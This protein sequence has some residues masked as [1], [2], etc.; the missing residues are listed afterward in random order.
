MVYNCDQRFEAYKFTFCSR[1]L[2]DNLLE[3]SC[4]SGLPYVLKLYVFYLHSSLFPTVVF[5][6]M[7]VGSVF[8]ISRSLLNFTSHYRLLILINWQHVLSDS[9][10]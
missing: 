3:K 8:I 9:Y 1:Y 5:E 4:S 10:I 6:S 7:I 2:N